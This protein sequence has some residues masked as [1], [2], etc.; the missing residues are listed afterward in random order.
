MVGNLPSDFE[1]EFHVDALFYR[2]Q[3]SIDAAMDI[4]AMLVRDAG[5]PPGSDHANLRVLA[6]LDTLP[7]SITDRLAELNS[8]R[9][10]LVHRYNRIDKELA[11]R[12]SLDAVAILQDFVKL[13][14][15]CVDTN[16]E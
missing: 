1:D 9:N 2:L 8:F 12:N 10:V 11:I 3:T 7:V 6:D 15:Q 13:V 4:C 14:S 16:S 5:K